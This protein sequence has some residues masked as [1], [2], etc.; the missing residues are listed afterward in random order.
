[1]FCIYPS[2][3]NECVY[4]Y[5]YSLICVC[6]CVYVYH[7][8]ELRL[9]SFGKTNYEIPKYIIKTFDKHLEEI[10]STLRKM[11][12]K[13]IWEEQSEPRLV[14]KYK[15]RRTVFMCKLSIA[16]HFQLTHVY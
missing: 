14:G 12:N 8:V 6:V 2:I 10:H 9:E 7:M 13:Y 5:T 16:T 1:M 4:L 3:H 11:K 15:L